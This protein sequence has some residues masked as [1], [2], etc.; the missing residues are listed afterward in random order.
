MKNLPFGGDHTFGGYTFFVDFTDHFGSE[1]L[2]SIFMVHLVNLSDEIF[3]LREASLSYEIKDV[4]FM[5][6]V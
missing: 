3:Y 6:E 2:T 4:I 1:A 5:V